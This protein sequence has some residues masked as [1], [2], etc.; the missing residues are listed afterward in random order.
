[1]YIYIQ[2][3]IHKCYEGEIN[4]DLRILTSLIRASLQMSETST[5][6]MV[7]REEKVNIL[8][9]DTKVQ[10]HTENGKSG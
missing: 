8:S 3:Q 2:K 1:M 9:K 6:A 4:F 7:T 10:K 5:H